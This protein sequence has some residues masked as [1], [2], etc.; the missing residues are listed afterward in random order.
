MQAVKGYLSD[1]LFTPFNKVVLPRNIEAMLVFVDSSI[2]PMSPE[3]TAEPYF[4]KSE[5]QA[6]MEGLKRIEA[7]LELA[8][9]E[10]LSNFP[11]QGLMKT[12]YEDWAD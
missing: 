10:D 7:T 8:M 11:K 5:I 2:A 6:R 1:G 12:S 9:D 4:S 3:S